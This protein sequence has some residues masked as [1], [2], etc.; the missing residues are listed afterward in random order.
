MLEVSLKYGKSYCCVK[1]VL[2]NW[3]TNTFFCRGV[4]EAL[5]GILTVQPSCPSSRPLL[6]GVVCSLHRE[7]DWLGL[8]NH[9]VFGLP[10][11]FLSQVHA[12]SLC[13]PV[14][15][16]AWS[17]SSM[18]GESSPMGVKCWWT[19]VA[20]GLGMD[21]VLPC[22]VCSEDQV[23]WAKML[24]RLQDCLVCLLRTN[25]TAA[26]LLAFASFLAYKKATTHFTRLYLQLWKD[27][28]CRW[29]GVVCQ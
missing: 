22:A 19:G 25:F 20:G 13:Q 6:T 15:E 24:P 10:V 17:P 9:R 11:A 21:Q 26:A 12:G 7:L 18:V 23:S 29:A 8:H 27:S 1:F 28:G 2:P 16:P 4:R 14:L 5:K 3:C